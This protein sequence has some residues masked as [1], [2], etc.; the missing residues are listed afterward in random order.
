MEM[1]LPDV[2][3]RLSIAM[4]KAERI[5]DSCFV[6]EVIAY[7]EAV[8]QHIDAGLIKDTD[9]EEC[10]SGLYHVNS[11]IWD[12]EAD[13]WLGKEGELG[14]DEVGRRAL[15]IRGWNEKRVG[16][17][18]KVYELTGLGFKDIKS[19]HASEK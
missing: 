2:L 8:R 3:D 6:G 13:I 9:V 1:P 14:L 5:G 15:A 19:N 18:N 7:N 10:L 11:Q 4:L 12:L 17:R 16:Y